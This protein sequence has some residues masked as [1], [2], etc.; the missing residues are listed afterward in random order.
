MTQIADL[1]KQLRALKLSGISDTLELRLIEA[2]GNQLSHTQFLTMLL[3]D[4]MQLR[5]QRKLH[6]L[7]KQAN[8][9]N[10]NTLET[11]D[12]HFNPAINPTQIKTLA[13][14]DFMKKGEN[15]FF[16]G[17]TG[18][19]KTHLTKSLCHAACRK[20]LSVAY[21]KFYQ[22]FNDLAMAQLNNK[23]DRLLNKLCKVDLFAIDDFAFRKISSPEAEY[24]YAIVDSRYRRSSIILNS[25]R[26][27]SD[28]IG[29]FPDP[30]IANA[31]L[32]RLAQNAHQITIKGES[33]RKKMAPKK[34]KVEP[35]S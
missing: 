24:L 30:I 26:D 17:P 27:I 14:C 32:D 35:K 28:W 15:V 5:M 12:F 10:D 4:E 16:L 18:T 7:I 22:L 2:Q 6:R 34:K 23:H 20:Y 21:Y 19:G 9:G 29:I 8:I 25:N 31:I 33:Y 3:D 13:T 11:F 1:Q